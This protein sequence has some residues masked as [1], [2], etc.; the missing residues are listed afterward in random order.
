[1]S[2]LSKR[3][4]REGKQAYYNGRGH[5]GLITKHDFDVKEGG[6]TSK[7]GC[8]LPIQ[9]VIDFELYRPCTSTRCRS[10]ELFSRRCLRR[11]NDGRC[12]PPNTSGS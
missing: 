11:C 1:M 5:S 8:K 6:Q 9:Y 10:F 7:T 2:M 3:G 12:R 4:S